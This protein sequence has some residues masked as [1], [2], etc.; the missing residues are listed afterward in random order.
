MDRRTMEI[1]FEIHSGLPRQGPG[2]LESTQRAF[3]LLK[4]IPPEPLILDMGCGPGMQTLALARLSG[5]TVTA[6]DNHQPFLD[7]LEKR[8][9]RKGLAGKI[10]TCN[11]DM[12]AAH[13]PPHSFDLI[14]AEGSVYI[15]GFEK[16]L[17]S[18]LS[19]LKPGGFLAVSEISWLKPSPPPEV[20]S[21]FA[22]EYPAMQ[23]IPGNLEI[24]RSC[25]CRLL[26]HFVLP[27][28]A[29]WD[30]Y[31]TPLQQRLDWLEEK[32]RG[33]EAAS[34]LFKTERLEIDLFRRYSAYYGYVFYVLQTA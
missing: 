12:L 34:A 29:W 27:E 13:F 21:F 32:Y 31:Y 11:M 3:S 8:A 30:D 20:K 4:G 5:G 19:W 16:G 2:N 24:I 28:S 9:R 17:R 22:A 33:D 23:D 18:W 26:G 10:I 6:V 25:G 1:F 15:I 14:W 7:E